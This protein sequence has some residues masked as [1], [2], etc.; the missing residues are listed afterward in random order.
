VRLP[1]GVVSHYEYD[2]LNRLD[3]LTEYVDADEDWVFDEGQE[4]LLATYDYHVLSNGQRD[5]VVEHKLNAD[6]A[7]FSDTKISWA[8]DAD[9]RLIEETRDEN[10]DG[11]RDSGDYSTIF[12]FDLASNRMSQRKGW[13]ANGN[14][15]F[16]AGETVDETITYSYNSRDGLTSETSSLSGT[17]SYTY[18]GNGSQISSSHGGHITTYSYGLHNKMVELAVNYV[19][20]A[21][22]VYDRH[23]NR[24]AET[25]NGTTTLYLTD[26]RNPTG[27]SQPIEAK[28]SATAAPNITYILGNSVVGQADGSG[29]V[30]YLLTDGHGSTRQLLDAS[31][32][33]AE[34]YNYDAF[35]GAIGF[36]AAT[37]GTVFLFGGDAIYD[38]ASGLYLHGNGVRGRI[39]FRFIQADNPR[40]GN[41]QE[42]LSLHKYLYANANPIRG[43]DPSGHTTALELEGVQAAGAAVGGGE[44]A[45]ISGARAL[46]NEVLVGARMVGEGELAIAEGIGALGW[47]AVLSVTLFNL[48]AGG[49]MFWWAHM[50]NEVNVNA[51]DR[52]AAED[53]AGSIAGHAGWQHFPDTPIEDLAEDI[54]D[55]LTD[56]QKAYR[57]ADGRAIY[58]KDGVVVIVNPGDEDGGTAYE[59]DDP[60]GELNKFIKDN[61]NPAPPSEE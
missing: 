50:I 10:G 59:T 19:T 18:D 58:I 8:Y 17:T 41:A 32:S 31:G 25:S 42:P 22:Y 36:T 1:N 46:V 39:G 30:S 47:R 29:E 28:S 57:S 9:G 26:T 60:E 33:V 14:G 40:F 61:P 24:V 12:A 6:N 7:T 34:V 20:Q 27:Y 43:W 48:A 56:P 3:L 54:F 2:G 49:L 15:V 52:N 45:I 35:G 53:L 51:M 38:P 23:Q 55:I 5:Y 13:D 21:T 11:V 16:D 37:A 44:C 4:Q